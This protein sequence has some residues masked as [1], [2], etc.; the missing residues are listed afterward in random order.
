MKARHAV[1][2]A[3]DRWQEVKP[4]LAV[5]PSEIAIITESRGQKVLSVLEQHPEIAAVLLDLKFDD[6]TMQ[7]GEILDAIK[8][9][10]PRLPVIIL[11]ANSDVHLALNLVRDK[12]KAYYY[13]VKDQ[14]DPD[15]FAATLQNAIEYYTLSLDSLRRTG[16]G[17]IIGDSPQIKA[18]LELVSRVAE[19]SH[20]VMIV[21][22][23]GT[24][25]ELFARAIHRSS[26]RSGP[27]VAVNC[28]AISPELAPAAFFGARPGAYTGAT[29]TGSKGFFEEAEGGTLFLD[30]ITEM[31]SEIQA[32]LLRAVQE[33]EIQKVGGGTR[34]V[35]V[36]IL[37]A[38]NRN[39]DGEVKAR[40]FRED[41]RFR[42]ER[43]L[44]ALP[45]LR[46]HP[47]DVPALVRE[48]LGKQERSK[49]I[50]PGAMDLLSRRTW[51]GNVRELE[52][53][54]IRATTLSDSDELDEKVIAEQMK[55]QAP[56]VSGDMI[57]KWV[58]RLMTSNASWQDLSS[59]FEIGGETLRTIL[60]R[61]IRQQKEQAQ[62][63]P[64]GNELADALGVNRNHVNQILNQVGIKLRDYD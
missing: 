31:P 30:E 33:N 4:L 57:S 52:T 50:T 15:Q 53:I 12:K 37:A 25:K 44:I 41:L 63:R 21:G 17:E 34:K 13:F 9:R 42:L 20:P 43:F 26:K 3:D 19:S 49:S 24:G 18:A 64:T 27:F 11:T 1:L 45:P 58:E 40:R 47:E 38:T 48:F 61:F 6:Q 32:G 2:L 28:G 59:E 22:E 54:L 23:T 8:E 46:D 36:R 55:D 56:A 60:D 14:L 5:L 29:A 62:R 39:L 7:G 51:P 16:R 35:D 10:H